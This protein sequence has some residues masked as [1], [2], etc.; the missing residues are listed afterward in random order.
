MPGVQI[1]SKAQFH[2]RKAATCDRLAGCARS[3][4]EREQL[5]RMRETL[6]TLA[7][8]E[9]RLDGL[10]PL[11]PAGSNALRARTH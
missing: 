1:L 2:R 5:L 9:E 8:N 4:P 10:P 6:L 3:L 7:T 11:P